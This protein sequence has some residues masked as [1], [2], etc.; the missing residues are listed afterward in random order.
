MAED[1]ILILHNH[2]VPYYQT[3]FMINRSHVNHLS[4][5]RLL[6]IVQGFYTFITAL[7][8]IVD[9][10]SFMEITGPKTDIWLV[11][12]FSIIL[13]A[14][15]LTLL[16]HLK[17]PDSPVLP[18]ILLGCLTSA[19]LAFIDFFYSSRNTISF[20]YATDGIIQIAFFMGWMIVLARMRRHL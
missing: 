11:K 18:A 16:S 6:L 12:T 10:D 19:G 3:D 15:G 5:Y 7:W 13:V 2:V 4:I 14:V 9:I 8:A 1:N 17:E 20:V